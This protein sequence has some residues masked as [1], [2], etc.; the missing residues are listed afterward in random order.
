MAKP[1]TR[2]AQQPYKQMNN[3]ITS[4]Q[5][6]LW[7]RFLASG[8]FF[9]L[10]YY[11]CSELL[12]FFVVDVMRRDAGAIDGANI[13]AIS[14][15]LAIGIVVVL[16]LL[17]KSRPKQLTEP[18]LPPLSPEVFAKPDTNLLLKGEYPPEGF[19]CYGIYAQALEPFPPE[20]DRV[21][22]QNRIRRLLGEDAVSTNN[23]QEFCLGGEMAY[24]VTISE[25]VLEPGRAT[26][27]IR[28]YIEDSL[29]S[30]GFSC[31]VHVKYLCVYPKPLFGWMCAA[32]GMFGTAFLLNMMINLP[33]DIRYL[34]F[35]FVLGTLALVGGSFW[36][37]YQPPILFT[38]FREQ[39]E[40]NVKRQIR[41]GEKSERN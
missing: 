7:Q 10:L 2:T 1:T 4:N 19:H 16:M 32:S 31:L 3:P 20:H 39:A 41:A 11:G 27:R 5:P 17:V 40:R 24:F 33:Q 8:F 13:N 37:L 9:G 12:W 26:E 29:R 6:K 23:V 30:L 21:I 25:R 22:F 18:V 28:F 36:Y 34:A 15:I 35:F 14:F 38:I